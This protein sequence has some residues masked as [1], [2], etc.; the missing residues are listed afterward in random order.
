M[1][2][3]KVEEEA[4]RVPQIDA[5]TTLASQVA[6]AAAAQLLIF[7]DLPED[8][9]PRAADRVLLVGLVWGGST[10]VEL[11]QIGKGADLR[12]G[13]LF[14]LPAAGLPKDFRIV[15]H[16][17]GTHVLTLPDRLRAEVHDRGRVVPLEI[18]GREVRAPFRGRAY[19]LGDDDRVVAQ[20]SPSLTLV[21]RYVRAAPRRAG[22]PWRTLDLGFS[23]ALILALFGL[24]VFFRQV[25][26]APAAEPSYRDAVTRTPGLYTKYQ[27]RP[28]PRPVEPPRPRDLSGVKE[29]DKSQGE[30]GKL[31]KPEAKAKEAAPSKPGSQQIDANKREHD[32]LK[33]RRLGLLAAL[34][35]M[36]VPGGGAAG[37]MAGPGGLGSGINESLGG[38]SG[39]A[40]SG[41]AWGLGGL[42]T[43]G[44]GAGGGGHALGIGGLGTHGAGHGR[45]GSGALD[46][47]G[48]GKDDTI[49]IPGKTTV[50]GGLSR[51]VINR[52]IQKHYS[53][54]KYCYEKELS[55]DP[56]LYGKVTVLFM[57]DGTGRV[58]DAL[59][60][61]TTMGSE[62]V[63]S[64]MVNHV[65]RWVFPAP[66]GGS[67]VQVTYPYVF[68]SGGP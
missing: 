51:D 7:D 28:A 20:I 15:Q 27:V 65:R 33:V 57:I 5:P 8:E 66:Q 35:K 47:G 54:I 16:V 26:L 68:K 64:C 40:G 37:R 12:V 1:A 39:R 36:G 45:G 63:E 32:L 42:G 30:E 11:E 58:G 14:D 18:K 22:S 17:N 55:R 48:R 46:L 59:V 19:T 43:R 50:V 34:S 21:A 53:E 6:D 38:T 29:G 44:S 9:R 62:P 2:E 10:L 67:T 25:A 60:Q 61:Q 3:S 24:A 23:L 56:G 13:D 31:G 52:V 41:D 49:F 4:M